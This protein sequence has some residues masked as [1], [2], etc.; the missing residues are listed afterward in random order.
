MDSMD[1]VEF[2]EDLAESSTEESREGKLYCANCIHCKLV[3]SPANGVNQFYLRVRCDAGKWRKKLG[4]E[5]T[6]KYFTVARRSIPHCET[7]I[8]MGDS[9]DFIRDLK[10]SL[11]MKD[12]PLRF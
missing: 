6:Y 1:R 3:P 7:Y 9:R 12:E 2:E 5:K 10:K 8:D 4:D 11:P